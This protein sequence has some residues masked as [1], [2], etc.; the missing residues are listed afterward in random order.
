MVDKN[1]T[2]TL[3]YTNEQQAGLE[4]THS[5]FKIKISGPNKIFRSRIDIVWFQNF[6]WVKENSKSK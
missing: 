1:I 5:G 6:F 3:K 4:V 2:K